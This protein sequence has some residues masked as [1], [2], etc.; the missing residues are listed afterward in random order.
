MHRETKYRWDSLLRYSLYCGGVEPSLQHLRGR[1]VAGDRL[2][3]RRHLVKQ[4]FGHALSVVHPGRRGPFVSDIPKQLPFSGSA[5]TTDASSLPMCTTW[6]EKSDGRRDAPTI[7]PQTSA[8]PE[9]RPLL[10]ELRVPA[11]LA[12]TVTFSSDKMLSKTVN[13]RCKRVNVSMKQSQ[14]FQKHLKASCLKTSKTKYHLIR[15]R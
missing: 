15:K 4:G 2:K 9:P 12:I 5:L 1:P 13:H 14:M 3:N 7:C 6:A 11:V 8:W 10:L